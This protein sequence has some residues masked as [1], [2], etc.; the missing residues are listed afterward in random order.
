MALQEIK[1]LNRYI[2]IND[3]D[4]MTEEEKNEML[5]AMCQIDFSISRGVFNN[6][7]IY[8]KQIN[9]ILAKVDGRKHTN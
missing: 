2:N 4:Y 3:Y 1:L 9:E 7:D 6:T 5:Y 8:Y